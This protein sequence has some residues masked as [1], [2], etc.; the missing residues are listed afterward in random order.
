MRHL[1]GA[2][3]FAAA[4]WL[5][6][7]CALDHFLMAQ[8]S[9]EIARAARGESR[10]GFEFDRARDLI[11][12]AIDNA[13]MLPEE[14][15]VVRARL[16]DGRGNVRLNLRGLAL[17]ARR[18]RALHLR[19]EVSARATLSLI[20][21]EPG[22]LRQWTQRL[23]LA[24]GWNVL[25][26][27]LSDLDWVAHSGGQ[28][29]HWGG[30]SGRVGEFRLYLSGAP[31]LE[32][33]LD[34]LRFL[35]APSGRPTAAIEW[36]DTGTAQQ[37]LD[38]GGID[39]P[40]RLGVLLDVGSATPERSLELRERLR[41]LDAEVLFWPAWR[42]VPDAGSTAS[43]QVP[44]GWSPGWISVAVYAGL[45]LAW[46]LRRRTHRRGDAAIE[47]LLGHAPLL[48]L[49][50][51]LGLAEQ[52]SPTAL[53]WL[54]VALAFQLSG[55]RVGGSQWAGTAAAWRAV[56]GYS[57]PAALALLLIAGGLGH[58]QAPGLERVTLYIPFVLLQ[59]A[60]LLG[61]LLP[62]SRRLAGAHGATLATALFALAHAPNF[63]LMCLTWLIGGRWIASYHR[64]RSWLPILASHYVLGLLAITCLPLGWLHSAEAG[65]RFFQ[66]R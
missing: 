27:Q 41:A 62:Q 34:H 63:T 48:A 3:L 43:A 38:G 20:F 45:A 30:T 18:F 9:A 37:M 24:P 53:T 15:G 10:L 52:P 60:L 40:A 22:Q 56:A 21:D 36:V 57:L 2:L 55:L 28:R 54:S 4:A 31:G 29:G 7:Q 5:I 49:T 64:H 46:R 50:L 51:G 17:D 44:D 32:V 47:L 14:P 35:E 25:H 39:R 61:F 16:P 65:L 26:A 33:A 1:L 19:L 42:G 8:G 6:A 12:G 13:S 11:G 66:V 58:W 59:Q 23:E